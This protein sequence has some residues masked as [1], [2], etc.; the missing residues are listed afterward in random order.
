MPRFL[1]YV[2]AMNTI[3]GDTEGDASVYLYLGIQ[4]HGVQGNVAE[5]EFL[6]ILAE[7]EGH[8]SNKGTIEIPLEVYGSNTTNASI[9]LPNLSVE[10]EGEVRRVRGQIFW[11]VFHLEATGTFLPWGHVV[12]PELEIDGAGNPNRI[13]ELCQNL[14]EGI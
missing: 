8:N 10:A 11:P 5:V 6:P 7:A 4:A 12:L 1:N 3:E 14:N 13:F 2:E 9:D